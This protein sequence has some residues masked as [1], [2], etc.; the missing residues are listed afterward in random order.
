MK[1]L[2]IMLLLTAMA[3]SLFAVRP[4][5]APEIDPGTAGTAIALLSGS[6]LVLKGRRAR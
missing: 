4:P 5:S 2:G 3:G 1:V 6:L